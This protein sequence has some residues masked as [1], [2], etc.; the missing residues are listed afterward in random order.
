MHASAIYPKRDSLRGEGLS[1]GNTVCILVITPEP[2]TRNFVKPEAVSRCPS[3]PV[4]EIF[5]AATFIS[6]TKSESCVHSY[7]KFNSHTILL[8]FAQNLHTSTVYVFSVGKGPHKY[9]LSTLYFLFISTSSLPLPHPV[10][11]FL[12]LGL[13]LLFHRMRYST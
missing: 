6:F 13:I 8:Y 9:N 11:K 3:R 10:S 12:S 4:S 5:H 1:G 2:C 7:A